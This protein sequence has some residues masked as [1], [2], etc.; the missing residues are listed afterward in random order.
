MG[1]NSCEILKKKNRLTSVKG[2][3]SESMHAEVMGLIPD[4][5]KGRFG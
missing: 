2:A 4:S 3:M 5:I 1:K